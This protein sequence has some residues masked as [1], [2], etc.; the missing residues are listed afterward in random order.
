MRE[1]GAECRKRMDQRTVWRGLNARGGDRSERPQPN[2][3][4]TAH[5]LLENDL[6]GAM[7]CIQRLCA[8]HQPVSL[9]PALG[10]LER[11]DEG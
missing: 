5:A 1:R 6:Q 3:P 9:T 11:R 7:L 2:A 10:P 8:L 4:R